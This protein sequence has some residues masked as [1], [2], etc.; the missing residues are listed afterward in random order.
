M[1]PSDFATLC[2]PAPTRVLGCADRGEATPPIR[3]P[4]G[5]P[6]QRAN[7]STAGQNF[8]TG[9]MKRTANLCPAGEPPMPRRCETRAASVRQSVLLRQAA[10]RLRRPPP[11]TPPARARWL[12]QARSDLSRSHTLYASFSW[13]HRRPLCYDDLPIRLARQCRRIKS[14]VLA[15]PPHSR[16]SFLGQAREPILPKDG[17]HLLGRVAIEWIA[18]KQRQHIGRVIQQ[19][20][21]RAGHN[22]VFAPRAQRCEPQIPVETRL[23]RR[24]DAGP[25]RRILRFVTERIRAPVLAITRSLKLDLIA[26]ARHHCK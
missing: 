1:A 25:L 22:R 21:L 20:L 10:L 4:W 8:A 19:A 16:R 5:V 11:A 24:I 17:P 12:L 15:F 3:R 9:E 14:Q 7:E 18:R 26:A 13:S 2:R 23:I 6:L